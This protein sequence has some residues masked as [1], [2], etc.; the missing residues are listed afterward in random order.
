M[1]QYEVKENEIYRTKDNK[2]VAD[3]VDGEVKPTAPA[4]YKIKEELDQV[5][6]TAL[7]AALLT[8]ATS[9]SPDNVETPSEPSVEVAI[10]NAADL[11]DIEDLPSVTLK[12]PSEPKEEPL[13]KAE[14]VANR[15]KAWSERLEK[16]YNERQSWE[17]VM[18]E[19]RS[20][21]GGKPVEFGSLP[22]MPLAPSD[23]FDLRG[24]PEGDPTIGDEKSEVVAWWV[25]NYP[26]EAERRYGDR[27]LEVYKQ[28]TK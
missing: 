12:M 17:D 3:I 2:K 26:R 24:C 6:S 15:E 1:S 19:A 21:F 14:E 11:G 10:A 28:L 5:V 23:L 9:Q 7:H 27:D 16:A 18:D 8:P 4:Y 20:I 13:D 25:E 22:D